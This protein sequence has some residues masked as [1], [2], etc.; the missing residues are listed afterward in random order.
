[1]DQNFPEEA[2]I[3]LVRFYDG[4]GGQ[5]LMVLMGLLDVFLLLRINEPLHGHGNFSLFFGKV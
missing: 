1:M 3:F 4:L 2:M 5:T